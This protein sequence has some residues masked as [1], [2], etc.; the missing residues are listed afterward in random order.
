MHRNA[1][2]L[3]ASL[4]MFP[5]FRAGQDGI[6]RPRVPI[7]E[8]LGALI[9]L[10]R[11]HFGKH[12]RTN[13]VAD[14][15]RIETERLHAHQPITFRST[16]LH[17]RGE[18]CAAP[19]RLCG[20]IE[21]I[22]WDVRHRHAAVGTAGTVELEYD[23]ARLDAVEGFPDPVIVSINVER[24]QIDRSDRAMGTDQRVDVLRGDP[25]ADERGRRRPCRAARRIKRV[26]ASDLFAVAVEQQSLPAM[27]DDQVGGVAFDTI[28]GADF[29]CSAVDSADQ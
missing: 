5:A 10:A 27:V 24:Q 20:Q 4:Y 3:L 26:P 23:N 19:V 7:S 8:P 2:E 14:E 25:G 13:A 15:E 18:R 21:P 12:I 17:E 9:A 28:A 29:H 1:L 16:E 6:K 11:R 22:V